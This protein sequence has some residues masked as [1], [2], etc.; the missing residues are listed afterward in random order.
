LLSRK[1]LPTAVLAGA[2]ILGE[3]II[4]AARELSLAIP[5]D[6][7]VVAFDDAP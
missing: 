3:A 7:S 6:L 1:P 2:N 4:G 5:R